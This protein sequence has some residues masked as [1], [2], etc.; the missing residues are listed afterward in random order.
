MRIGI[1]GGLGRNE[2][3]FEQLAACAGHTAVIHDGDDGARGRRRLQQLVEHSDLVVIVT[4]INSHGAVRH[5]RQLLRERGRSP[6]LMRRCGVANFTTLLDAL[7][8][9]DRRRAGVAG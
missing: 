1:V 7:T 8:R 5:A 2:A 9:Q 6:L 4:D 3:L